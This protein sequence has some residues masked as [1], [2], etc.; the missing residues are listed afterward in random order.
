MFLA[1]RLV[2]PSQPAK[3][4]VR[5]RHPPTVGK[6]ILLDYFQL[7]LRPA[8]HDSRDVQIVLDLARAV[9]RA[10]PQLEGL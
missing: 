3:L 9:V 4:F 6:S 5:F 8:H 10:P 1:Q 2:L 7:S